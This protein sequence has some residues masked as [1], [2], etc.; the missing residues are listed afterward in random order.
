MVVIRGV[1][2]GTNMPGARSTRGTSGGFRVGG[3]TDDTREANATSG[4]AGASAIGLLAVQE[5]GPASERDAR[6][7][8]RGEEM[9]QELKALQ[10]E[11]L[12]GR[13]DPGRLEQLSRLTEGEKPADPI[14]AEAL[15]A[16]VL[17]A[18]LELAK[19]G[20]GG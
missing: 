12:E 8:R 16:V 5:L 20:I 4:V 3:G 17:R 1:T 18:R 15:E 2:G 14:L 19:R 13:A 7:F 10:L 9:L 11:L 6:A